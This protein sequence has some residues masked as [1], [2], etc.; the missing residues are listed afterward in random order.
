MVEIILYVKAGET[1]PEEYINDIF[2]KS[3]KVP[4]TKVTCSNS[5][6]A[7]EHFGELPFLFYGDKFVPRW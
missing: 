6:Q 5:D 2:S 4:L 1:T 3:A 7:S